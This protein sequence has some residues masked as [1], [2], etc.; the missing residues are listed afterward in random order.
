MTEAM[1][2]FDWLKARFDGQKIIDPV[3]LDDA[4]SE[5]YKLALTAILAHKL[6]DHEFRDK[7][8][9]TLFPLQILNPPMN[10]SYNCGGFPGTLGKGQKP[11]EAIPNL[12]T[13]I[14]VTYAL[15]LSKPV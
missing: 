13:T 10:R 1:T 11:N 3:W 4:C 7:L 5:P 8:T 6:G 15:V 12:E 14:L 9:Q 2:V